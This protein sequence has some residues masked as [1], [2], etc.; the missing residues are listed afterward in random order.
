[1]ETYKDILKTLEADFDKRYPGWRKDKITVIKLQK[2]ARKMAQITRRI[3]TL[4]KRFNV[5]EK[6]IRKLFQFHQNWNAVIKVLNETST[7]K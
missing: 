6:E 2:S 5:S 7:E 3:D 4:S 1:M